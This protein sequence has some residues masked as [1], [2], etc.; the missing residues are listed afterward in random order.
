MLRKPDL[1]KLPKYA[2]EYIQQLEGQR[3]GAIDKL[4]KFLDSQTK[5]QLYT[6]HFYLTEVMKRYIQAKTVVFDLGGDQ[7]TIDVSIND[8]SIHVTGSRSVILLP[9][10]ANVIDISLE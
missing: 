8:G 1:S 7:N 4:N 9:R 5:S 10:C 6:K 3:E 2:Q